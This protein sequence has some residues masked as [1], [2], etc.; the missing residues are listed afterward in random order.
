MIT[1]W[2]EVF[3]VLF[4]IYKQKNKLGP[5]LYTIYNNEL[6]MDQST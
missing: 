1:L 4:I 2:G 6:K 3:Y 5:V